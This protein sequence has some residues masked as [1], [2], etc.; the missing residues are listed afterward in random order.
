MVEQGTLCINADVE[1]YSGA[2]GN[3]T[4]D[5]QANTNVYIKE[6]EG[7]IVAIARF[8]FVGNYSSLTTIS[9]ETL[10]EATAIYAAIGVI[11]YDMS[12]Y[13]SRIEAEDMINILWAKWRVLKKIIEDQKWVTF[14]KT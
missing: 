5:A 12:G 8:D 13:T 9:Q 7:V 4:A 3:S 1:F 10:R 14:A 11:A 6:A 2:N